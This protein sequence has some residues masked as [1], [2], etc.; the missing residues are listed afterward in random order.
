M[1]KELYISK[2]FNCIG[3]SLN[4]CFDCKYCRLI[5]E[6][7]N[8]I[9]YS[10]I[11][12]Q[13]NDIFSNIPIAINLFYGDPLLQISNTVRY[14]RRLENA[15]HEGPVIVITKGDFN[16]F[17]DQKFNLDLHF[18]FSAFGIEESSYN[19]KSFNHFLNNLDIAHNRNNQYKYSIEFRPIIYGVNDSEK[20]INSVF[21]AA[22][23]YKLSVGFSGLQGKPDVVKVW[24]NKN[25][26]FSPYPGFTFGHKKSISEEKLNLIE[27]IAEE[28]KVNIFRK[29]S[30][31]ISHTHGL[32]RDYN[33]HYYRP[34]ELGCDKCVMSN[35]CKLEKLKRDNLEIKTDIVPF[36]HELVKKEN[37][38]CILKQKGICEFPSDDCSKISGG[39]IK[40]DEKI[41]TADVRVIK[42]LTGYTIDADFYESPY[43]SDNWRK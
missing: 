32:D 42:W 9:S 8:Q 25:Y 33:A 18:A 34:S 17:P 43:L 5:D 14:L 7:D 6:W 4:K 16:K 12:T 15:N 20:S 30:C 21:K 27:Q 2:S 19:G 40:I 22:K 39:L 29:T 1:I 31:L 38:V 3:D 23:D 35:K 11:P 24:N 26:P 28:N 41:S 36:T 13:I 10:V 37:H